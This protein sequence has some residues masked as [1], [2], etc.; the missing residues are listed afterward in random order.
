MGST[1]NSKKNKC[2][3]SSHKGLN[4]PGYWKG[5]NLPTSKKCNGFCTKDGQKTECT[6]TREMTKTAHDKNKW[7]LLWLIGTDCRR[8]GAGRPTDS[9]GRPIKEIFREFWVAPPTRRRRRLAELK[10]RLQGC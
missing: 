1:W 5:W 6:F 9:L 2:G 8:I 4:I 3:G 10:R 7:R